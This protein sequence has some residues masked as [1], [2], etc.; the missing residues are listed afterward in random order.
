[1]NVREQ[2]CKSNGAVGVDRPIFIVG[3]PRSGTSLLR[4]LLHA[5]PN[6]AFPTESHF[7]PVFFKA[8][9]DPRSARDAQKLAAKILAL[10]WVRSWKLPLTP[11]DFAPDKTFRELVIRLY[12]A[13]A[14][15]EQKPRWGDKTPQYAAELP[16][17][18]A[19][20]PNC[21]I[22]HLYRDGRDVALSYL[23]VG[24]DPG[25][26]FTAARAWKHYVTH[27]RRDGAALPAGIYREVRYET[28]LARP[29]ETLQ[30]ICAFIDEPFD[31]VV[32]ES[33]LLRHNQR[34]RRFGHR[35][36]GIPDTAVV[37]YNVQKWK[38]GMSR[39]Q[40]LLFESVA[41]DLLASLGYETT[42]ATRPI[43]IPERLMWGTH[44][45]LWWFYDRL[46]SKDLLEW[47][48]TFSSM[49]IA[50]IHYLFAA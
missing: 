26:V 24:L 25:N 5:H 43:S 3:C 15:K 11:A 44:H 41:G 29:E 7:I 13:Y 40:R 37:P 31:A 22:I 42:G 39:R 36:F 2:D 9:G 49:T 48:A 38:T 32:F 4:D 14:R 19:L 34:Q 30:E 20:F 16:L 8:Y 47:S 21:K 1:M 6:L 46:N 12:R 50:R 17:L 35:D 45:A 33:N 28:L 10:R 27:G 23:E 18:H